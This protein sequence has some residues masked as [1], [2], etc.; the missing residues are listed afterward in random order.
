MKKI[1]WGLYS[2]AVI[3]ICISAC[4]KN[5]SKTPSSSIN[6]ALTVSESTIKRGQ[7]L[8]AATPQGFS[9]NNLTWRVNPSTSTHISSSNDQA[10]ILVASPGTYQVV[11][12]DA[13]SG[14]NDSSTATITVTDEVYTPVTTNFDTVSLAGDKV[15]LT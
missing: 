5:N 15:T 13:A 11:A 9:S 10:M 14:G 12:V 4:S 8:V 6:A 7:P 1:I 3:S 2:V